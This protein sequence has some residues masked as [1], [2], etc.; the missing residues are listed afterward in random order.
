M[1]TLREGYTETVKD[2]TIEK[3]PVR[4]FK[5]SIV[6]APSGNQYMI[7]QELFTKYNRSGSYMTESDPYITD[8]NRL[9]RL[10]TTLYEDHNAALNQIYKWE[11]K[12]EQVL[13][14]LK[15]HNYILSLLDSSAGVSSFFSYVN[16]LI[17]LNVIKPTIQT[18]I[19]L[20]K[21]LKHRYDIDFVLDNIPMSFEDTIKFRNYII[22]KNPDC[23]RYIPAEF[24]VKCV[25]EKVADKLFSSESITIEPEWLESPE[26]SDNFE[27][28]TQ[29]DLIKDT[30]EELDKDF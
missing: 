13:P 25:R 16:R 5:G 24:L 6:T 27:K 10:G 7:L 26:W 18:A 22:N 23:I 2:F 20:Y 9:V 17:E 28:E 14:N 1:E 21:T 11:D 3:E 12:K 4:H 15:D 8:I 19:Y 30:E 29:S